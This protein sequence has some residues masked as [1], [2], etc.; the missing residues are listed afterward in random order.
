V[1]TIDAD[2]RVNVY[3][4]EIEASVKQTQAAIYSELVAQPKVEAVS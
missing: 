1:L 3:M 4:Q 2:T